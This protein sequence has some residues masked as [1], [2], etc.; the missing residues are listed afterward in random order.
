MLFVAMVPT[1]SNGFNNAL[2]NYP[3]SDYWIDLSFHFNPAD[4]AAC[5]WD[6][7]YMAGTDFDYVAP[8]ILLTGSYAWKTISSVQYCRSFASLCFSTGPQIFF[9]KVFKTCALLRSKNDK[10]Y[11]RIATNYAVTYYVAIIGFYDFAGSLAFSIWISTIGLAWGT[12][13]LWAPREF[14]GR[15]ISDGENSWSFG[16]IVPMVML[17]IPIIT[18]FQEYTGTYY[19]VGTSIPLY[20]RPAYNVTGYW[21]DQPGY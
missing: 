14:L 19:I 21:L 20:P 17:V 9:A 15:F 3:G 18:L 13:S 4:P 1:T 16:Q 5:F 7:Q 6:T 8:L 2:E 11:L 10:L 12:G